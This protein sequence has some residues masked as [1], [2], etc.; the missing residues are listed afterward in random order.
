M[1]ANRTSAGNANHHGGPLRRRREAA[2]ACFRCC[3]IAAVATDSSTLLKR[4]ILRSEIPWV[5]V[6]QPSRHPV[7]SSRLAH[8]AD[9]DGERFSKRGSTLGAAQHDVKGS[10]VQRLGYRAP[11]TVRVGTV[12]ESDGG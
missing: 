8:Q 10:A 1:K 6:D 5:H 11:D 7:G 4:F 12:R 3:S 9:G 2:T